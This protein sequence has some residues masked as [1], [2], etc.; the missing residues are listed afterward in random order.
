ME[1]AHVNTRLDADYHRQQS[2]GDLLVFT[3]DDVRIAIP[4]VIVD[5]VVRMVAIIP[6]PKAPPG[7]TGIVNYHGDVIPVFSIRALFSLPEKAPSSS[8]F[9]LI[10][11][12]SRILAIIAERIQGVFHPPDEMI[13]PE[14]ILQGIDGIEGVYRCDDGLLILSNPVQFLD[15]LDEEMIQIF[16]KMLDQQ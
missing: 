16:L 7:V 13:T 4:A 12:S 10:I 1:K 2:P 9:L 8:D 6:V 14:K 11:N 3:V 15:S 5:H